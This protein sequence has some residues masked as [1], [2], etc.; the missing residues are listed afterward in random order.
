MKRY[1][2]T[3]AFTAFGLVLCAADLLR[4]DPDHLYLFMFSVPVWLIEAFGDV[5]T[6][7]AFA[8]YALTVLFWAAVGKSADLLLGPAVRRGRAG[9]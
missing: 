1:A 3:I 9:T 6:V 7:N 5:H 8:V 4:L 2:Y